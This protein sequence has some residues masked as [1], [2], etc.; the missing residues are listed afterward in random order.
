MR[1]C[2]IE[3]VWLGAITYP[4]Y[5]D[6]RRSTRATCVVIGGFPELLTDAS[7]LRDAEGA[8]IVGQAA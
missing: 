1:L 2:S 8:Q 6:V 3:H 4:S 5:V 7:L